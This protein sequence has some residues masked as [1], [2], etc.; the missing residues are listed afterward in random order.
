MSRQNRQKKNRQ[1]W[2]YTACLDI[3]KF[4]YYNNPFHVFV[5]TVLQDFAEILKF[6][7]TCLVDVYRRLKSSITW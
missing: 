6:D 7:T 2:S 1:T 5:E 3:G 4:E